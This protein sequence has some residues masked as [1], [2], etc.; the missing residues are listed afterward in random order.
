MLLLIVSVG[1][2]LPWDLYQGLVMFGVL[3]TGFISVALSILAGYGIMGI[4]DIK[5]TVASTV[6]P[7]IA[8]G[9]G[10]DDM[11]IFLHSHQ[12]VAEEEVLAP[13]RPSVLPSTQTHT[14][15]CCESS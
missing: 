3:L 12:R 2:F 9:L 13:T 4:L 7:L 15:S 6:I 14:R 1:L 5:L 8:L 11:Y 10:L